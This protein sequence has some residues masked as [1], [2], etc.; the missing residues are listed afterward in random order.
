MKQDHPIVAARAATIAFAAAVV[1]GFS[2]LHVARATDLAPPMLD[3]ARLCDNS[4]RHDMR[5]MSECV[6]AESEARAQ[7]LQNWGR[8][9]NTAAE[10]CIKVGRKT[11]RMPY[12]AMAR[13]LSAETASAA[14]AHAASR[15][16]DTTSRTR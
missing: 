14:P 15:S 7:M 5:A 9:S 16:A 8:Y 3:V 12:D 13:C 6:V 10:K 11:K 4:S 2:A 1:L